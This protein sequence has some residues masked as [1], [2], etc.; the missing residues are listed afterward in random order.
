[1]IYPNGTKIKHLRDCHLYDIM[2][3]SCISALVRREAESEYYRRHPDSE[4]PKSAYSEYLLNFRY[5]K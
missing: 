2:A 4:T 1:M 3:D 5:K